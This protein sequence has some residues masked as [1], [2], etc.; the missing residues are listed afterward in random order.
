M[1]KKGRR[2]GR[3]GCAAVMSFEPMSSLGTGCT[4]VM[5]DNHYKTTIGFNFAATAHRRTPNEI[6]WRTGWMRRSGDS[7]KITRKTHA[8]D[9]CVARA[10][11]AARRL[12]GHYEVSAVGPQA[13]LSGSIRAGPKPTWGSASGPV[14]PSARVA[15]GAG[16]SKGPVAPGAPRYLS[17]E[18][19]WM[20]GSSTD[21][22]ISITTPPIATIISGSSNVA[23]ASAR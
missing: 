18:L 16:R 2:A 6:R 12:D 1:R 19:S 20:M 21:S 11:P 23:R 13:D 10:R 4:V 3:R 9:E 15:R 5:L 7:A 17:K 8:T 14:G 22:T